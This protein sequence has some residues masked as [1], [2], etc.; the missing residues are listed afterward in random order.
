MLTNPSTARPFGVLH[1]DVDAS[2][3]FHS[4]PCHH[5]AKLWVRFG[6]R[7][8]LVSAPTTRGDELL[9]VYSLLGKPGW[10]G[11]RAGDTQATHFDRYANGVTAAMLASV[12]QRIRE[13][14]EAETERRAALAM[15]DDERYCAQFYPPIGAARAPLAVISSTL[16][17]SSGPRSG[18]KKHGAH[19]CAQLF[20]AKK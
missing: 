3:C 13:L 15:S 19:Q 10:M 7:V 17:V 9:A 18:I 1:L 4:V 11:R 8:G 5:A 20:P 6:A 16:V 14:V 2:L 12:T